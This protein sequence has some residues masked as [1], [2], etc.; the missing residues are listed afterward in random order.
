MES[1]GLVSVI[2][3][4]FNVRSYLAEALDSVLNQ[5]YTKLEII[6]IDDG[7]TDGSAT[8]CDEYVTKDQRIR[9]VHQENKGLS[10]AR[11]TGL[12]MMTGEAVAFLDSDDAFYPRFVESMIDEMNRSGTDLVI[13]DYTVWHTFGRMEPL[14]RCYQGRPHTSIGQGVYDRVSALQFLA[15][16]A[17]SHYSWNKLKLPTPNL[18]LKP[19]AATL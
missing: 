1:S 12:D 16:G 10:G 19:R 17:Y 13:C 4:V 5:T 18:R 3:P 14:N 6:I 9:V 11:N 15:E 8:I 7:S 2:I